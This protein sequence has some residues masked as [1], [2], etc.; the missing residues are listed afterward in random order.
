MNPFKNLTDDQAKIVLGKINLLRRS[1][2]DTAN[3]MHKHRTPDSKV[4]GFDE[5]CNTLDIARNIIQNNEIADFNKSDLQSLNPNTNLYKEEDQQWLLDKIIDAFPCL[6]GK[7][8]IA[9]TKHDDVLLSLKCTDEKVIVDNTKRIVDVEF[10]GKVTADM[11]NGLCTELY[12]MLSDLE[13][14]VSWDDNILWICCDK[15]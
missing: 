1:V 2:I 8:S 7:L 15:A 5:L 4:A 12:A 13:Y 11:N 6:K 10:I 14:I 3:E 9:I